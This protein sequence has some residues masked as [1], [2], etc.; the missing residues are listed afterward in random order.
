MSFLSPFPLLKA[1]VR[2]TFDRMT[3]GIFITFTMVSTLHCL[4]VNS[5]WRLIVYAISAWLY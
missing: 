5:K 3:F 2:T 1:D 4:K